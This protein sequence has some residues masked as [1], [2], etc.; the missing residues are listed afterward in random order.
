MDGRCVLVL[1]ITSVCFTLGADISPPSI[2]GLW[3]GG[4]SDNYGNQP[5]GEYAIDARQPARFKCNAS[6]IPEPIFVWTKNGSSI[7]EGGDVSFENSGR[8]LIISNPTSEVNGL[9]QCN[10]TSSRGTALS[11][12]ISARLAFMDPFTNLIATT[13]TVL[14]NQMVQ[15]EC[16]PPKSF[17]K[18]KIVWAY[19]PDFSAEKYEP[20][21]YSR[22]VSQSQ[23]GNLI[24]GNSE[25]TD[26]GFFVCQVNNEIL[27]KIQDSPSKRLKVEGTP[28]GPRNPEWQPADQELSRLVVAG[29]TMSTKC[30]AVGY[31]TPE[32]QWEFDP[33]ER[34]TTASFGQEFIISDIQIEDAG[35]YQC[36]GISDDYDISRNFELIV[37]ASPTWVSEPADVGIAPGETATI[38]CEATGIP[39][40]AISWLINGA[41]PPQDSRRTIN[42]NTVTLTDAT[43][44]DNSVYQCVAENTHGKIMADAILSVNVINAEIVDPPETDKPAA[45]GESVTLQCGHIGR[46]FPDVTWEGKSGPITNNE[47]YTINEDGSLTIN[48][49]VREDEGAYTCKVSNKGAE[50]SGQGNIV[51]RTKTTIVAGVQETR[52]NKPEQATLQC[53]ATKDARAEIVWSWTANGMVANDAGHDRFRYNGDRSVLDVLKTKVSDTGEYCC[54]ASTT[55]D[56]AKSCGTLTVQDVPSAPYDVEAS[57]RG[58]AATRISWKRSNS[59]NSNIT[60]YIIEYNTTQEGVGWR[61]IKRVDSTLTSTE[62]DLLPGGLTFF[63]RVSAINGVGRSAYGESSNSITTPAS[64]PTVFPGNIVGQSDDETT[65]VISWDP[66]D[67][68]QYGG[69][70]FMYRVEYRN[71]TADGWTTRMVNPEKNSLTIADTKTYEKFEIRVTATNDEGDGPPSDIVTGYSGEGRPTVAPGNVEVNVTSPTSA[72]V[73]FDPVTPESLQGK[74]KYY[75][76]YYTETIAQVSAFKSVE[77]MTSP[78]EVN[79][80]KP[81][82]DYELHV[83]VANSKQEGPRSPTNRFSTPEAPPGQPLDFEIVMLSKKMKLFW[84]PANKGGEA[85]EYRVKVSSVVDQNVEN[86]SDYTYPPETKDCIIEGLTPETTY[87]VSIEGKNTAGYGEQDLIEKQTRK[88]G[89]PLKPTGVVSKPGKDEAEITWPE[90][91]TGPAIEKYIVQIRKKDGDDDKPWKEEEVDVFDRNFGTNLTDLSPNTEY[92]VRLVAMNE[93][94]DKTEGPIFIITT[95]GADLPGAITDQPGPASTIPT[96][97]VYPGSTPVVGAVVDDG[98]LHAAPWLIVMICLILLLLIILLILCY[99][100]SQKGGK[101]N[102]SDKEDKLRGDPESAPLK[103]DEGGFGEYKPNKGTDGNLPVHEPEEEESS[104]EDSL[105]GYA[106]GITGNFDEDGSFIGQYSD[107]RKKAEE[108]AENNAMQS[109]V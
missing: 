78:C 109:L 90:D 101:Y 77:C 105:A 12:E 87:R 39:Q 27:S 62:L 3:H 60:E 59:K 61:E 54:I 70:G 66:M 38:T 17:P 98:G 50:D 15:L 89:V 26:K 55:Y 52:V 35:N 47:K 56:L 74:F 11:Q 99:V 23:N 20:V 33:N 85:D 76:V 91:K 65:M 57:K 48:N 73:S 16:N 13:Y 9:Y 69:E 95:S 67:V 72:S 103:D 75:R 46:P 41:E 43:T 106:D 81:S 22:R 30:I 34:F 40:P 49:V 28:T 7:V 92:E 6:G 80:L 71:E 25:L 100:R 2:T 97:S 29:S 1:L 24:I 86:V 10:A 79:D 58:D 108:A 94:G 44:D 104:D 68:T 82:T 88:S 93:D 14:P 36:Y 96:T 31:P 8:N 83:V 18:L 21:T 45:E 64:S 63:F 37:E 42:G 102:V 4:M 32:I 107:K 51:F 5:L 84:S 19:K 53:S